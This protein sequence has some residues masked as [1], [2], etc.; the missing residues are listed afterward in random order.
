METLIAFIHGYNAEIGAIGTL[1]GL[2]GGYATL[3]ANAA[4]KQA[5]ILEQQRLRT[6][7]EKLHGE[8]LNKATLIGNVVANIKNNI[9]YELGVP[10]LLKPQIDSVG[11]EAKS[12]ESAV[13][14]VIDWMK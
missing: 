4:T 2:W 9:E 7:Q 12:I 3:Q 10:A 8:I 11:I 13:K 6:I 1:I 14:N 5:K